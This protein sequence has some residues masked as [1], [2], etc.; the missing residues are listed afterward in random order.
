MSAVA[1]RKAV[2]EILNENKILCRFEF[3]EN[4]NTTVEQYIQYAQTLNAMGI[5]LDFA[6]LKKL[7][8]L[9]FIKDG[10]EKAGDD[11]WTPSKN[12]VE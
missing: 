5:P 12:E 1:V 4:D 10:S 6:E 11:V 2:Y 3:V 7:T 8:N 9:S